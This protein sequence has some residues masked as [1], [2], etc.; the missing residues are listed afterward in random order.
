MLTLIFK[1]N[2]VRRRNMESERIDCLLVGYNDLDF[3]QYESVLRGMGTNSGAYKDLDLNFIEF[4]GQLYPPVRLLNKIRSEVKGIE[5]NLNC[6]EPLNLAVAYLRSYLERRSFETEYINIFQA[7]KDKFAE[8]LKQD[9][10][11]VAITTTFYVSPMPIIEIINFIRQRNSTV[12][13]IIGGPYIGN[14]FNMCDADTLQYILSSLG[15]DIYV[16]SS[17]GEAELCKIVDVVVNKKPLGKINNI[18]Y[19]KGREFVQTERRME[20]IE[21]DENSIYWDIFDPVKLGRTVQ[22]RTAR[23]CAYSCAFCGYPIR[24]GKYTYSTVAAVEKELVHLK[25]LGDVK[26]IAFIDDTF[27]VPLKRFQEICQMMIRNNYNYIWFSYLRCQNIDEETVKLMKESG[28][29]GV[30]LGIESGS[31]KILDLMNKRATIDEYRRGINLLKKAGILTFASFIV[32]FPGETEETVRE[33]IEFIETTKPDFYRVQMWY[34]DP[35]TPIFQR[36]EKFGIVG[37]SFE[38]SHSTMDSKQASQWIDDIFLTI[39]DSKWLPQYNFDFWIIPYL[40]GKGMSI[41]QFSNFVQIFNLLLR[42]KFTGETDDQD[43]R[44]IK[45]L[46]QNCNF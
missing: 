4:Q 21:L 40:M 38:W 16:N 17:Q 23:G 33:T 14:Q 32:G 22:L 45:G 1:F 9:V 18:A 42:K 2:Y 46:Q 19:K 15:G 26:N 27:N 25:K 43:I 29:K 34:C 24:G 28:C 37:E 20:E 41:D 30:F 8:L 11:T 44:I 10:K 12:K 13:I 5:S 7:E 35:I 36:Q 3:D 39:K 31:S 6:A